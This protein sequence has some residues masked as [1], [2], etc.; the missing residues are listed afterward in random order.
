MYVR[1]VRQG[2]TPLMGKKV[3]EAGRL[4]KDQVD[5]TSRDE[6]GRVGYRTSARGVHLVCLVLTA[7]VV[8]VLLSEHPG[9]GTAACSIIRVICTAAISF[10]NFYCRPYVTYRYSLRISSP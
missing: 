3:G 2:S 9:S 7:G 6:A 10:C 5:G 8:V 1:A 4:I